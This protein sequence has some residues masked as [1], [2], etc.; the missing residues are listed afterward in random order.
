VKVAVIQTSSLPYEK[1]KINY[2]L[3]ILRSKNVKLVVIGE[4]VLNLFFKE[5]EKTPL[6]FIKKQSNHQLKLFRKLASSYDMTIIAPIIMVKKDKIYKVFVKFSPKS[7]R[8]YYQQLF[9]PYSHWNEKKFFSTKENKPMIFKLS[10]FTIGVLPGF[11]IHFDEFWSYFRKKRVD[12]VLVPSVG[13]FES[14]NRWKKVLSTQAFLNNCYVLRANRVGK[15]EDWKF[16]GNS[17][18]ANPD[19]EIIEELSNKEELLITKVDKKEVKEARR[20]WGFDVR[21]EL[22]L[23]LLKG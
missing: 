2:Y 16:Y 22:N 8:F 15:Y 19:G 5:L 9:M 10:G 11:E 21:K 3:S 12:L 13:T 7:T 23:N 18:L 6:N 17:F 1:A 14:K 20:E 4:Y